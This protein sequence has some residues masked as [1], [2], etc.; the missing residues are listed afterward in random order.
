MLLLD[1]INQIIVGININP[2]ILHVQFNGRLLISV[3]GS[4]I[5]NSFLIILNLRGLE[6]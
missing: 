1:G 3:V 6:F 2:M 5:D 4:K